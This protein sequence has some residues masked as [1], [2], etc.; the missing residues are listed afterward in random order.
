MTPCRSIAIV[1]QHT[2]NYG[3]DAAGRALIEEL[4]E[5]SPERLDV[6]Y[7]WH[8]NSTTLPTHSPHQ[9]NHAPEVTSGLHDTRRTLAWQAMRRFVGLPP[10]DEVRILL[11]TTRAAE[12]VLVSPAGSNLGI[13]KDWMYLF[14][15]LILVLDGTRPTFVQ[16]TV[17]ESNSLLFNLLAR[18]V[19]KRSLVFVR[20]KRSHDYLRNKG[21]QCVLGVDTALLLTEGNYHATDEKPYIAVVPTQLSNWHR[22][23]Q[24]DQRANYID[25]LIAGI[26]AYSARE[27]IPVKIVPHLYGHHSEADFLFEFCSELVTA[28]C[29][30]TISPVE[31]LDDYRAVIACSLTVVSM[32]YHGLVLAGL[33]RVPCVSL[34]YENKMSEAA[35]Y[36]GVLPLAITVGNARS[37][38]IVKRLEDAVE[39]RD[40]WTST[41]D[42]RVPLLR[43]VAAS[44]LL[45]IISRELRESVRQENG[46]Q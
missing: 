5:L 18:F 22:D 34:A 17:G 20:E 37:N 38:E 27:A 1:N 24:A 2:N 11:D 13:Y 30:A 31:S 46:Y 10:S 28:G 41:L 29:H 14:I 44:P 23:F 32:R 16:N 43:R 39:N 12:A 42:T 6:F 15:L 40:Y 9:F 25:E 35:S 4:N 8:A 7:I 33:E 21:I 26:S 19:L 36:L 45:P 3:D